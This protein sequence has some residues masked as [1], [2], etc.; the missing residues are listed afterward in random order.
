[1]CSVTLDALNVNVT[2]DCIAGKF[3]FLP[4]YYM[5]ATLSLLEFTQCK[6]EFTQLLCTCTCCEEDIYTCTYTSLCLHTVFLP[7]CAAVY[8]MSVYCL[9]VQCVSLVVV[10]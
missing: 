2:T 4:N 9:F 8:I 1:M 3:I 10:S 7:Y 6:L 5:L